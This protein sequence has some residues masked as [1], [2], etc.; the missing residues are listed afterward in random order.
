MVSFTGLFGNEASLNDRPFTGADLKSILENAVDE[1]TSSEGNV[2]GFRHAEVDLLCIFDETHD[3]M[4]IIAAVKPYAE[5]TPEEKDR[6]F[7]AN[8]HSALDARYCASNGILYAAYLHPLSSLTRENLL[9]SVYQVASL[10]ISFGHD[11]SSGL[12]SFGESEEPDEKD[13]I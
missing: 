6:M 10:R 7:S 1:V 12:L 11:Y 13:S 5:V 3:R 9:S 2:I 4:R 8:F